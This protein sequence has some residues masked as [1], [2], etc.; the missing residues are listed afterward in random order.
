MI[1]KVEA[2]QKLKK[3]GVVVADDNSIVTVLIPEGISFETGL[4]DVRSK[5][6]EIGYDASFCV[7]QTG[8]IPKDKGDKEPIQED[9]EEEGFEQA[10]ESVSDE[11]LSSYMAVDDDGQFS[12]DLGF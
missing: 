3:M 1:S 11:E 12:L 6:A 9:I 10:E 8:S 5:L 7:K 4:K 2:L